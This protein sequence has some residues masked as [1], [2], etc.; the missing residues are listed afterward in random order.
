MRLK[1]L[2]T[3]PSEM[4]RP[5]TK[6]ESETFITL[7]M[8][9]DVIVPSDRLEEALGEEAMKIF[10]VAVLVKRLVHAKVAQEYSINTIMFAA[11]LC[12]NPGIV[13]MWAYTIFEQTRKHGLYDMTALS[14]DFPM[15]FPTEDG[16]HRLWDEQKLS[17]EQRGNSFGD[18]WLDTV[19]AWT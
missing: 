4:T 8:M 3:T 19:E 7:M 1:T 6:E 12:T 5:M 16:Y 13:V 18:N 14:M 15:G 17:A 11:S 9:S 2:A 10:A